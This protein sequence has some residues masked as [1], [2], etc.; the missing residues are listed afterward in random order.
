M[1]KNNPAITIAYL[2][3]IAIGTFDGLLGVIWPA[4]S[5]D[6]GVPLGALGV[7]L[8]MALIGFVLASFNNGPLIRKLS[9]HRFLLISLA[10]RT[11]GFAV[12]AIFPSWPVA[13]AMVLIMSIGS[14][15]IDS[16]LNTYLSEHGSARQL[17][18][19]HA[20][21]GIGATVGPFLAAA[22][23]AL[24]G[25][26]SWNFAIIASVLVMLT[27]VV[28]RTPSLW[29]IA[30]PDKDAKSPGAQAKFIDSLGMP[31]VWVSTALFFFYVGMELTAGQWSFSL[32]TLGRGIPD[33][34][35]KFWVGIYWGTFTLGR[36]LFGL[37][38]DRVSI[39][40]FLRGTLLATILGATLLWWNPIIG[41]GIA[42]LILMG[43]AEAPIYPSLIASTIA[44]VGKAH[45]A[46]AIGFQVAAAGVGG[47][48]ITGLVGVM[49]TGIGLE[50]IGGAAFGLAI[51]TWLVHEVLLRASR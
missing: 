43:L 28:W 38:A 13:I 11:I 7:L 51:I 15:G 44:R 2:C 5:L 12:L 8:F 35:A 37:I 19:L 41:V 42:G 4:M 47:T 21:F 30:S 31:V 49:A 10:L 33:L 27:L 32:F 1:R 16:S 50:A 22:V 18:W 9:F 39:D 14:G 48:L 46:N 25:H 24:G 45:A 36:I 40:R 26:W 23:S 34:T 29:K 20:S 17:N 3:Y 6:F